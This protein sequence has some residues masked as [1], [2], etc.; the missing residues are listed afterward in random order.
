MATSGLRRSLRT[1]FRGRSFY[2]LKVLVNKVK[3]LKVM[4]KEEKAAIISAMKS[5][6]FVWAV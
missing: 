2:Y 3:I 6:C 5:T 4:N 1:L